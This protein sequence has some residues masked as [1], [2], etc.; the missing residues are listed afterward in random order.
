MPALEEPIVWLGM[1]NN[2]QEN[3]KLGTP[4]VGQGL[5][6]Y[7]SNAGKFLIPGQGIEIP[8]AKQTKNK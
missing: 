8:H 2:S 1:Q 6:L 5:R 3:V 4:L 7:V